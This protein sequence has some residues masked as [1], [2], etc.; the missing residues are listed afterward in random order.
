MLLVLILDIII[1]LELGTAIYNYADLKDS[2]FDSLNGDKSKKLSLTN[3]LIVCLVLSLIN[4]LYF[5]QTINPKRTI[6]NLLL[7]SI[8]SSVF[9]YISYNYL[10]LQSKSPPGYEASKQTLEDNSENINKDIKNFNLIVAIISSVI[11]SLI[12]SFY[13]GYKFFSRVEVKILEKPFIVSKK[14]QRPKLNL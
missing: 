6:L 10:E 4:V 13:I 14:F 11:T 3:I 2:S 9:I 5:L 8:V 1:L 7:L 12:A